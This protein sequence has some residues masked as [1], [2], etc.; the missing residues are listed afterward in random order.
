MSTGYTPDAQG[1]LKP[2]LAK[3]EQLGYGHKSCH[4][5]GVFNVARC[6]TSGVG[7]VSCWLGVQRWIGGCDWGSWTVTR[8]TMAAM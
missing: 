4:W 8:T 7:I 2:A 5:P 3:R 6:G 1:R